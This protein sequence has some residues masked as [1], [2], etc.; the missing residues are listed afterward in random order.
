VTLRDRKSLK[1]LRKSLRIYES[2]S[3]VEGCEKSRWFG[4]VE[5]KEHSSY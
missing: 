4:H 3:D 5:C 1:E 2:V